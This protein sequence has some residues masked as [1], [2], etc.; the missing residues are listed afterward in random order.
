MA[1]AKKSIPSA[2]LAKV[3]ARAVKYFELVWRFP[4]M[5]IESDKKLHAAYAVL[6]ELHLKL[7]LDAGEMAYLAVLSKLVNEYEERYHDFDD[8]SE[9]DIL[10]TLIEAKGVSQADV[11]RHLGVSESTISS[12]VNGTRSLG[13]KHIATLAEYFGVSPAVLLPKTA[14]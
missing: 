9:A 7:K 3:S 10:E 1:V 14:S 4:L 8:V 13:K 6:D 11:A 12:I 2:K 5:P